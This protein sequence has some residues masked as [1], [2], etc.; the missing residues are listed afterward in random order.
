MIWGY[1]YFRKP[2]CPFWVKLSSSCKLFCCW[3][4]AA[5]Q[6]WSHL[7]KAP[8]NAGWSFYI[9][10]G[11]AEATRHWPWIGDFSPC[12]DQCMGIKWASARVPPTPFFAMVF[13]CSLQQLATSPDLLCLAR[14]SCHEWWH[15]STPN[16]DI[17]PWII[18]NLLFQLNRTKWKT[19]T[20]LKCSVHRLQSAQRRK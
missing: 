1:P 17:P 7:P 8:C 19:R 5:Q 3:R 11:F 13:T 12:W 4:S 18:I 16:S 10:F 6:V 9:F 2:S 15:F 20:S 14:M